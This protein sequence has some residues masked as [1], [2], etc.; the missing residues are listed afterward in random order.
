[1]RLLMGA[2]KAA[3]KMLELMEDP[4]SPPAVQLKAAQDLLDRAGLAG[5]QVL[6]ILSGM[7]ED[8]TPKDP[9]QV[10]IEGIETTTRAEWRARRGEGE[11]L[12]ATDL[13]EPGTAG[14]G[15]PGTALARTDSLAR[16]GDVIDAEW[17]D[18]DQPSTSDGPPSCAGCGR[19]FPPELPPGLREYPDYCR[20][21]RDT[22]P[23][24]PARPAP[25][26]VT[27]EEAVHNAAAARRAK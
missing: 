23:P 16:E 20:D 2:D 24:A 15:R 18:A 10:I 6:A 26:L 3:M 13:P 22:P 4:E 1:M 9:W 17:W 25:Q 19:T 21:C 5:P 27:M 12:P 8:G 11:L 14:G 7:G